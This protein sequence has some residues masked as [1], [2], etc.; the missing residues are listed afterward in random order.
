MARRKSTET[1]RINTTP[2]LRDHLIEEGFFFCGDDEIG[3]MLKEKLGDSFYRKLR[4]MQAKISKENA[5]NSDLYKIL[6]T[7]DQAHA[8]FSHQTEVTVN[9][10][11]WIEQKIRSQREEPKRIVDLGCA[12]G[13]ITRWIAD[14]FQ[15]AETFSN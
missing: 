5:T 7:K 6:K 10:W 1:A 14:K 9:T 2:S 3:N 13:A 4:R 8:T 15:S 11:N 12:T